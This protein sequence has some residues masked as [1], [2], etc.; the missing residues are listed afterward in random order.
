MRFS[1][2]PLYSINGAS[3]RIRVHSIHQQLKEMGYES[4]LGYDPDADVLIVQ[5]HR[6][7]ILLDKFESW[8]RICIYDFDDIGYED[9]LQSFT[10]N[11]FTT[12]TDFHAKHARPYATA[13]IHVLPDCIDYCPAEP[14]PPSTGEGVVW[15]GH[16]SNLNDVVKRQIQMANAK[17]IDGRSWR[18]ET[19]QHDLRA[20]S[21]AFLSHAGQDPGKSNNKA[22]AAITLG[23][24]VIASDSEAYRSL[25]VEMGLEWAYVNGPLAMAE[26]VAR[27]SSPQERKEYLKIAQPYV[28]D[29][30]H[31]RVVAQ[32]LIQ[33]I[34]GTTGP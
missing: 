27:L 17:M 5:K 15:F 28:W 21:V 9:I 31:P 16:D 19:F 12:D 2:C 13:P 1:W 32:R 10:P 6:D 22:L 29:T 25:L 34:G 30:Y 20:F 33:L 4:S 23:L 24:P 26:V 8:R 3:S 18:R 11:F 14:L 7:S